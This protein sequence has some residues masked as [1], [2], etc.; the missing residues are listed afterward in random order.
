MKLG[1]LRPALYIF[2]G[3]HA[4]KFGILLAKKTR[5][6]TFKS[7]HIIK[8]KKM[9]LNSK[10]TIERSCINSTKQLRSKYF[11]HNCLIGSEINFL[12]LSS[13]SN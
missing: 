11:F 9:L 12:S 5:R 4:E 6:S 13:K 10:I 7:I 2:Y 8:N 3:A 1:S